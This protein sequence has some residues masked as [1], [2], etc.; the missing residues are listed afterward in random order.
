M[1]EKTALSAVSYIGCAISI[2]CL[3][4]TIVLLVYYRLVATFMC[5]LAATVFCVICR[6]TLFE[7]IHNFVHL[8]LS[9]ALL[10]ALIIFVSGIETATGSEVSLI[11]TTYVHL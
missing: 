8:N 11:H 10:C 5:L 4:I 6:N 2:A 1:E 9:V 3:L 7:G